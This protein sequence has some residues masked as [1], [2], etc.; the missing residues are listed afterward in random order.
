MEIAQKPVEAVVHGMVPLS[1]LICLI[2]LT[3]R[4]QNRMQ[5]TAIQ[6]VRNLY[7]PISPTPEMN[8][9]ENEFHEAVGL[10]ETG[11]GTGDET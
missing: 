5:K 7:A 6:A 1:Q 11:V 4:L 3:P 2:V 10:Q 9:N 8:W